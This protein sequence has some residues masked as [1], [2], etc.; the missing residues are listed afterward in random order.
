M[1]TK[2]L[3]FLLVIIF[4]TT[5]F[6]NTLEVNLDGSTPYQSIQSAINN[7]VDAD[8]VLVHP[9]T[10]FENINF[11]GK[12]ITLGSLFLTTQDGSYINQTIIDGNQQGK[13]IKI[14]S[15][16]DVLVTGI[17]ITNGKVG[18]IN[19]LEGTG[20]GIFLYNSSLQINHCLIYNN[21]ANNGGGICAYNSSLHFFNTTIMEN[22]ASISGGGI[23]SISSNLIFDQN[24]RSNIYL[25]SAIRGSDIYLANNEGNLTV[26]VDTLTVLNPDLFFCC[27]INSDGVTNQ[28]TIDQLNSKITPIDADIYVSPFGNDNNDGLTENTSFKTIR[29]ALIHTKPNSVNPH[30]INLLPGTYSDSTNGEIYPLSSRDYTTICGVNV[31]EVILDAE[32]TNVF[33]DMYCINSSI[34]EVTISNGYNDNFISSF[35]KW[36]HFQNPNNSFNLNNVLISN[37]NDEYGVQSIGDVNVTFNNVV[38]KDN[39]CPL[40]GVINYSENQLSHKLINCIFTNNLGNIGIGSSTNTTLIDS[41]QII[42]SLFDNNYNDNIE[43]GSGGSALAIGSKSI[44]DI[45]NCTFADNIYDQPDNGGAILIKGTDIEV[46]IYNSILYNNSPYHTYV[47]NQGSNPINLNFDYSLVDGGEESISTENTNFYYGL[48]NIDDDP[49]YMGESALYPYALSEDSPCIDAGTLDLPEWI[50]LPEF[51]LAGN[52]RVSGE[53]IDM[54]C[55][56]YTPFAPPSNL[57]I[58]TET[59]VLFWSRPNYEFPQSYNLFLNGEFIENVNAEIYLYDFSIHLE[60]N[61]EYIAGVSAVYP[62]GESIT[63]EIEFIYEPVFGGNNEV[64]IVENKI[65]NYPNPFGSNSSNRSSGTTIKFIL[66]DEGNVELAIYNIKGQKVKNL[67]KAFS[68]KGIFEMQWNGK[69][70]NGRSVS[71]GTY[72]IKAELDGEVITTNKITVVK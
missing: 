16:E 7:S 43:W 24:N 21:I 5:L 53:S 49:L 52:P 28:I 8:T 41:I 9:G 33:T 2:L 47:V 17:T 12:Y 59:G 67:M 11:N 25:N 69:D 61:Q 38:Y 57:E 58:D 26:Y 56:E 62:N 64:P 6:S 72:L 3:L 68:G 42:N 1:K 51:D 39:N 4:F 29:Q 18:N 22:F 65:I 34:K 44:A 71:S 54:G 66:A 32:G 15:G 13:V 50:E 35:Y 37:S 70:N 27:S 23:C 30:N 48:N 10:Y 20:S 19:T 40:G 14:E 55:Y 46:N 60:A 31:N 36:D 45:V 63:A